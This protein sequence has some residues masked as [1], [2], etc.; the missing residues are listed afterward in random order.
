V[1]P[2]SRRIALAVALGF[3]ATVAPSR[4]ADAPAP[5][6]P[7]RVVVLAAASLAAAFGAVD[8][9]FERAQPGTTVE[10]SFAGSQILVQ[11]IREGAPADVF[12]AAD[13]ASMK[14]VADAGELAE[15]A[16][17]F[18]KN[19]LAIAV[20]PGNP[21]GIRTLADLGR[22]GLIVAL[23]GPSVPVGRYAAEAFKRAGVPVPTASQ[24]P[25]VKAVVTKIVLG[26]ADAGI[27]Y[28]TDV[29][30]AGGKIE[31][32]PI[33]DAH[34][35]EARYP[36]AVLRDAPNAAGARALVAFV[37][38]PDGQAVLRRFGFASP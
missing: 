13:E 24:E 33:P 14:A 26:E 3:L 32:V 30:A 5:A 34:N 19:R 1:T 38:G 6:A 2:I 8:D 18:A 12:A 4:A 15:P 22:P 25:D 35:V 7:G 27:V 23:G 11:Q 16:R 29:T 36:I 31:G 28:V 17:V 37:L 10:T 20:R 9:A 21:S